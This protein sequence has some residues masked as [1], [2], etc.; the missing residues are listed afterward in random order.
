MAIDRSAPFGRAVL[1]EMIEAGKIPDLADMAKREDEDEVLHREKTRAMLS[2]DYDLNAG[3]SG[4]D[5]K[6]CVACQ[7]N[8]GTWSHEVWSGVFCSGPCE[9]W[10][11]GIYVH[12]GGA[13]KTERPGGTSGGAASVSRPPSV[14]KRLH[15]HPVLGS[16]F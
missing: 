16:W 1:L 15:R 14:V 10:H 11:C 3:S 7:N 5:R 6:L 13:F 9:E 2:D 4:E 8:Y 12:S